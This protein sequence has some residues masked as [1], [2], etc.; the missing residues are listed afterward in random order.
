MSIDK[1]KLIALLNQLE[2]RTRSDYYLEGY[3]DYDEIVTAI[4]SGNLNAG[5]DE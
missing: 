1:Q 2:A 4:E 5:S 3:V